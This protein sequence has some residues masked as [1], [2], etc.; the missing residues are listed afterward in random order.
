MRLLARLLEPRAVAHAHSDVPGGIHDPAQARSGAESLK[1]IDEKYQQDADPEFRT[2]A[3]IDRRAVPTLV[4]VRA[5]ERTPD[6]PCADCLDHPVASERT[7]PAVRGRVAFWVAAL[8]LSITMLG[9]TLPTPL[10]V[11][12]QAQWHFSAAIV[13]VT[14]AV[15]AVAVLATLLLAGRSS[16]QAGRKPVL[17]AALGASALSTIVFIVAPDVGALIAARI[18]SGVSAGLMTGTATAALT[19]LVPASASR[20]A[21]LV[22]TA[23]NMGGLGLGPLIAGLFAQYAPQPTVLVFEVYLAVLAAAGLCLFLVPE[24]VRPRRRPA[25]RFA[26]LGIP[27]QGRSEFIAAGAAGFA[28]FSLLG[29]FAA[30]APTFLGNVLH[31]NSHAVQGGVV[32][33]LLAIGTLTQ[34]ALARFASRRVVLA[35]LG[36]FLAA[37]ALIVAALAQ[38]DMAL[39]LAGTVVGGMAVGA[40]FLGSLATAN[41]LAPPG[42][43]GQALSAFFVACYTGLIIPVVGVGVATEFISDFAAVLALSIL[44]ACL[45]LFSLARIRNAR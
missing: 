34:L 28:A 36:L 16:D 38:A 17:A 35:G 3:L 39:F 26:G 40:V 43:R 1:A 15:Y 18:L 37:L 12:Y 19:E 14:F 5:P 33:L 10:Y 45:C 41:R 31:Q 27:A 11:I 25:L 23:A 29:L 7:R 20:R 42:Q 24:T 8:I 9:T 4:T 6:R 21:S 44:L 2:R 13:T 22:A 32:F 30:L